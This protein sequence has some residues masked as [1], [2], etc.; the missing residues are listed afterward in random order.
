MSHD[1]GGEEEGGVIE[2]CEGPEQTG[3]LVRLEAPHAQLPA[4]QANATRRNEEEVGSVFKTWATESVV[5]E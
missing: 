5:G 2:A 4:A 3:R 1:G